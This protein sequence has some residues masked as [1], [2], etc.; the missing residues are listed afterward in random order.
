[1]K[2]R[3]LVRMLTVIL[4]L[5]A[6]LWA[7]I[8]YVYID[9]N[10]KSDFYGTVYEIPAPEFTLTNQDGAK[11]SL[12]D[13]DDKFVLLFFGYTNCPDI[14]PM[15]M[16]AMNNVMDNLGDKKDEVQVLFISVD[17]QRD[18]QDKIKGYMNYFNESFVGFTG[19]PEEI[20]KVT[21]DYNVVYRK[22]ESESASGYLIGHTSSVILIN[23]EGQILL[24][25]TQ[26]NMDPASIAGDI[27]RV[28]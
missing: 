5:I 24:R 1:M 3:N 6:I 13:F 21:D 7:V 19:T 8:L 25:Y 28:L 16:S 17:P 12:S 9:Q 15:T 2:R 18:S 26:N 10:N 22:E 20:G 14:C 11:A 4:V 27:E 23:P